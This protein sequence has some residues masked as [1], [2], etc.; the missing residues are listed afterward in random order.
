MHNYINVK[1]VVWRMAA[2]RRQVTRGSCLPVEE[3]DIGDQ[4]CVRFDCENA[5]GNCPP[6]GYE[7]CDG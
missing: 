1:H 4:E 6:E 3:T 5:Q 7:V 2:P